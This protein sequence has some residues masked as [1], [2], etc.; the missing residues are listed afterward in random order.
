MLRRLAVV[1][2]AVTVAHAEPAPV[3]QPL[4]VTAGIGVAMSHLRAD[5]DDG[6]T[7]GLSARLDAAYRVAP[8]VSVGVHGGLARGSALQPGFCYPGDCRPGFEPLP[9]TVSYTA[10]E[11]GATAVIALG[12]AWLAPWLGASKLSSDVLDA[13]ATL[14]YGVAAG[15]T[16][17]T[18]AEGHRLGVF[19][20]AMRT[21]KHDDLMDADQP[22][23]SVTLGVDLQ[24]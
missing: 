13:N 18:T 23:V 4:V 16:L 5:L 24:Y 15:Y 7:S 21:T 2:L 22:F 17:H 12:D 11:I 8:H 6:Y 19:A 9:D 10:F 14:G 1:P 20:S 3:E